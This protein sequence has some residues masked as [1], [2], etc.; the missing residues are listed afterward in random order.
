M[1]VELLENQLIN[2]GILREIIFF[3]DLDSTNKFAKREN[4]G[5]D[6]LALTSYQKEGRGRFERWWKSEK[7]NDITMSLVKSFDLS[8]EDIHLVTFYTSLIIIEVLKKHCPESENKFFLKWPNDILL[9]GKKVSGI[10]IDAIDIKSEKKK[11]IIGIGININRKIFDKD[12]CEK[13]TSLSLEF[14]RKF[15]LEI[16]ISDIVEKFYE[17][18][19]LLKEKRKLMAMWKSNTDILG[20]EALIRVFENSEEKRIK[21]IDIDLD[22]GIKVEIENEVKIKYFSGDIT[23]IETYNK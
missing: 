20:K 7:D 4:I 22:G 14:G 1:N 11:M 5:I 19:S 6:V 23:V 8:N 18:L 16:I 9:N 21:I 13:A 3:E 17:N 12:L 15:N 2:K 10:L